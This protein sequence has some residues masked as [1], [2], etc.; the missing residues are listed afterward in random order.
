MKIIRAVPPPTPN[1]HTHTHT[2]TV[3]HTHTHTHAHTHKHTH[4]HSASSDIFTRCTGSSSEVLVQAAQMTIPKPNAH[5]LPLSL[6]PYLY[7]PHYMS[8]VDFCV[9]N[10]KKTQENTR[11]HEKTR[12]N[13][14]KHKKTQENTRNLCLCISFSIFGVTVG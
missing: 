13:T 1:T 10:H 11:K 9:V 6:P 12:E 2:H 7:H 5:S 14:R 4:T 8:I 3:T